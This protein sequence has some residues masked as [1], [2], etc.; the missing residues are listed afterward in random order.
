MT[1]LH[2]P[3][4][5]IVQMMETFSGLHREGVSPHVLTDIMEDTLSDLLS[6]S[7]ALTEIVSSSYSIQ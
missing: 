4:E 3:S 6:K 1:E 7:I 5:S 2:S